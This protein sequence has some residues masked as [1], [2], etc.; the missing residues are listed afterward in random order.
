[1]DMIG[2][3]DK[4]LLLQGIG[5]SD[6][7]EGAIERRNAPIGVPIQTQKDVYLP[8]DATTFYL[9][10]VPILSAFTGAHEDYHTPRDTSDKINYP[11][12]RDIAK[13]MTL[14]ARGLAIEEQEPAYVKVEPPKNQGARGFRVY[15][16]T[17]PDYAQG[18]IKGVKLSGV[19]SDGPAAKAG[20]KGGDVII[21]LGGKEVLNIYDYTSVLAELKVGQETTI[22]VQRGNEELTLKLVPGSRD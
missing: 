14:I 10:Q 9:R 1:M 20:V 12:T 11:G 17:V 7:W 5:S 3:L 13:L 6:Y 16:G 8:T 15:L 22:K 21:G 2:R 19:S 18:D 4:A